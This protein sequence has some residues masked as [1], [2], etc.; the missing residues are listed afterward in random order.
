MQCEA[1]VCSTL[2][3]WSFLSLYVTNNS[4]IW[5]FFIFIFFYL[6]KHYRHGSPPCGLGSAGFWF[7]SG[8][9]LE[10]ESELDMS[11]SITASSSP[12]VL[13]I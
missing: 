13:W 12:V 4:V 11:T 1:L 6:L 2:H 5:H 7:W 10:D 9:D 3:M 8:G